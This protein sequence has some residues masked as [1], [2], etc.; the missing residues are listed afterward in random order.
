MLGYGR[1]GAAVWVKVTKVGVYGIYW[2]CI[3]C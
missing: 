1:Y 2:V 3:L